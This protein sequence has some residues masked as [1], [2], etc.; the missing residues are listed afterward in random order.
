METM[1]KEKALNILKDLNEL[2][3]METDFARA[4]QVHRDED[5]E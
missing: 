3:K 2:R 1:R 4:C 5:A